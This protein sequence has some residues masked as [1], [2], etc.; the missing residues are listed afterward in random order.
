VAFVAPVETAIVVPIPAAEPLVGKHRLALDRAAAWGVPAHVTVLYPF[1]PPA[2]LDSEVIAKVRRVAAPWTSVA[3]TFREVRWFDHRVVYLAPESADWFRRATAALV[4][5][6]PQCP[7]YGG[8]YADVIPHL[9]IG[10]GDD[11]DALTA[12]AAAIAPELPLEAAVDRVWLMQGAA[13]PASWAVVEEIV[14]T[15]VAR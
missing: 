5:A 6:F 2:Q 9:T 15:P 10:E 12:A 13:E 4:A 3:T 7:P 1:V 11:L 8:V 14:L